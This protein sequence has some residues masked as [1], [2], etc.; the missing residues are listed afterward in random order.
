MS[1]KSTQHTY[2]LLAWRHDG[3]A[4]NCDFTSSHG[5]HGLQNVKRDFDLQIL[6]RCDS[7]DQLFPFQTSAFLSIDHC[8]GHQPSR[9]PKAS[10]A[11][12]MSPT[13]SGGGEPA[14][15]ICGGVLVSSRLYLSLILSHSGSNNI[16]SASS[17]Q[18]TRDRPRSH[19]NTPSS[20]T[21]PQSP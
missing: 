11:A 10:W 3:M 7:L 12:D 21:C 19:P 9:S 20:Q 17:P 14:A 5:Y 6:S 2:I 13:R 18:Y 4:F 8:V 1:S 15:C 16:P